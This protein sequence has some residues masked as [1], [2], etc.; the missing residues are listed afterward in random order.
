MAMIY[1]KHLHSCHD[2]AQNL[3]IIFP[4]LNDHNVRLLQWHW[5]WTLLAA[6]I[7]KAGLHMVKLNWLPCSLWVY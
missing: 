3:E 2:R 6:I 1:I 4:Y 5:S 7:W